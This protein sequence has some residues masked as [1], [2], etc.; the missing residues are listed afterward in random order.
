MTGIVVLPDEKDKLVDLVEARFL[1]N[2]LPS[3]SGNS[4]VSHTTDSTAY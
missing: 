1:L 4:V 2:Y 3:K